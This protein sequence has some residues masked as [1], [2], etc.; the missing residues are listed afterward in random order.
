[1]RLRVERRPGALL[2]LPLTSMTASSDA[3][4]ASFPV[5]KED[6]EEAGLCAAGRATTGG[7]NST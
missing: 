5:N 2:T 1:L 7:G 4:A 6:A 3:A